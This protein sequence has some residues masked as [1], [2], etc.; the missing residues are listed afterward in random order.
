M[1]PPDADSMNADDAY[2][3]TPMFTVNFIKPTTAYST[4]TE[5]S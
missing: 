3:I 2:S 5:L 1:A 4:V